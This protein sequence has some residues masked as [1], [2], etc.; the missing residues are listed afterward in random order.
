MAAEPA[1]QAL[2]EGRRV[3]PWKAH[4]PPKQSSKSPTVH[5]AYGFAEGQ[6]ITICGN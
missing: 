2:G 3:Q 4:W 6:K 1:Q 5:A